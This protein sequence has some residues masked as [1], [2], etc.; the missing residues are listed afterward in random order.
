MTYSLYL[1]QSYNDIGF[2]FNSLADCQA[3][4]EMLADKGVEQTEFK[5]IVL[6]EVQEDECEAGG[7][8]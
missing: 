7:E 8:R 1:K 6:N 3:V 4:I 5:I 2:T